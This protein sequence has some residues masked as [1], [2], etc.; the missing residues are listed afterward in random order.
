MSVRRELSFS[1]FKLKEGVMEDIRL[2]K[3]PDKLRSSTD[4]F[5]HSDYLELGK[6]KISSENDQGAPFE[7]SG[8][9]TLFRQRSSKYYYLLLAMMSSKPQ[10]W[11]CTLWLSQQWGIFDLGR[12]RWTCNC[13]LVFQENKVDTYL[14]WEEGRMFPRLSIYHKE[15]TGRC[16]DFC[17]KMHN[18]MKCWHP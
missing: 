7:I 6:K 2:P 17:N 11:T 5:W 1:L 8:N 14:E 4:F 9:S 18:K 12:T 16:L 10:L 15:T 3:M 13:F